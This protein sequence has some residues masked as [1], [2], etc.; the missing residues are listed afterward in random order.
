M[1]EIAVM[2]AL[3]GIVAAMA[4][5][6][7]AHFLS[8][9]RLENEAAHLASDLRHLQEQSRANDFRATGLKNFYEPSAVLEMR[10]T[11]TGWQVRRSEYEVYYRHRLPADIAL[12]MYNNASLVST[13][14]VNFGHNGGSVRNNTVKLYVRTDQTLCRYVIISGMGRIRVSSSPPTGEY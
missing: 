13:T 4:L 9:A 7:A 6:R 14:S 8:V 12:A 3:V 11:E 2:F 10:F 1:A 5:P